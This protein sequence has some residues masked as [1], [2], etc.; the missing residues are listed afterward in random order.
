MKTTPARLAPLVLLLLLLCPGP[1]PAQPKPRAER[2]T[3][4]LGEK[5]IRSDGLF[6]LIRNEKDVYIFSA[7]PKWEIQLTKDLGIARIQRGDGIF[8]FNPPMEFKWPLEVGKSGFQNSTWLTPSTSGRSYP[9]TI[10]WKV[11]GYEDVQVF[12]GIFKAFRIAVTFTRRDGQQLENHLW[13]APEA[14][15]FVKMDGAMGFFKFQIAGLDRPTAGPIQFA[16][17][18]LPEKERIGVDDFT[19]GGKVT[20]GKGLAAVVVTVNGAEVA[21][22]D[23][24]R[25]PKPEIPLNVPVKLRDGKN[26]VIITATDADGTTRQEARGMFFLPSG[27]HAVAGVPVPIGGGTPPSP[28]GRP[29]SPGGARPG[30]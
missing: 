30:V 19:L 21:T 29:G 8:E 6:E 16:L 13:Y 12:E 22:M 2:P 3:Y 4:T 9:I 20:A 26:V 15:Q 10:Q 27:T 28:E 14:R 23:E 25:A 24:R 18:G 17:E 11:I 1:A 7:R 5:W